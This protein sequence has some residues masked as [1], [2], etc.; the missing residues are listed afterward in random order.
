[1]QTRNGWVHAAALILAI[2]GSTVAGCASGRGCPGGS[3]GAP[4][5]S[6]SG[7]SPG[8]LGSGGAGYSGGGALGGSGTR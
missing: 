4:A 6:S 5:A 7:Y 2:V 8:Y 1:M 3:C